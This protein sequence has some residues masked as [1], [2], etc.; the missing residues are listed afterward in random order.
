M[1]KIILE[2]KKLKGSK[3]YTYGD[4]ANAINVHR[5]TISNAMTAGGGPV[6]NDVL[7]FL[8]DAPKS[9]DCT[10]KFKANFIRYYK[11]AK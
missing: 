8:T 4:I 10:P 7:K 2:I 11:L 6:L 3:D 1:D 5:N 9:E